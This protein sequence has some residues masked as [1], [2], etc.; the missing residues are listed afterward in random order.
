MVAKN[1]RNGLI[2]SL[3]AP[4]DKRKDANALN[5]KRVLRRFKKGLKN[6]FVLLKDDI[7]KD[8]KGIKE[9]PK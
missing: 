9:Y 8:D 7:L 6:K 5:L 3:L 2:G 1:S 4:N